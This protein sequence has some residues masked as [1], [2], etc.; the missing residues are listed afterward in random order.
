VLRLLR[1]FHQDDGVRPANSTAGF[2]GGDD[3]AQRLT[4][5]GGG[6]ESPASRTRWVRV[7]EHL[8]NAPATTLPN[9][10]GA[11]AAARR[12]E[13]AETRVNGGGA[14]KDGGGAAALGFGE[15]GAAEGVWQRLYR[16]EAYA[17]GT[18]G[19]N[20]A[21]RT[22]SRACLGCDPDSVAGASGGAVARGGG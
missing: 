15:G 10:G 21:A 18:V 19:P 11:E 4:A 5:S 22:S 9:G 2:R 17:C 3:G 8:Q 12:R 6:D 7:R 16:A 1:G 20:E 13:A 14:T